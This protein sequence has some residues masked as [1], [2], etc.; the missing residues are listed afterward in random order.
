MMKKGNSKAAK[1]IKKVEAKLSYYD[2]KTLKCL[3][4]VIG[5]PIKEL[6]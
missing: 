6:D 5:Y 2:T 3:M 4:Q 1:D